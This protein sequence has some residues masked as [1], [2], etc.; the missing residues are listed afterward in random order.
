MARIPMLNAVINVWGGLDSQ[1]GRLFEH[2]FCR[3]RPGGERVWRREEKAI[4]G[5]QDVDSMIPKGGYHSSKG[6]GALGPEG[7]PGE[8]RSLPRKAWTAGYR[9]GVNAQI[10]LLIPERL[11][12]IDP[13]RTTG[14]Q[15]GGGQR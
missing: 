8:S 11:H 2:G 14:R 13:G 1:C 9:N 15:V 5:G 7:P 6:A 3:F 4:K 12:R 10:P